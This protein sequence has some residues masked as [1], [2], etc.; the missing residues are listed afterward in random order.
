MDD[1]PFESINV[2][3][4][5]DIMLVLLTIVLTTA[6]FISAGRIPVS[7]PQAS[8]PDYEKHK[9]AIIEIAA[10]G[11][12]YFEGEAV[13]ITALE[14]RLV[15]RPSQTPVLVRADRGS[16]FQSFVDVADVLKRLKITKVGIQTERASK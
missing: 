3:P 6:S 11:E 5:V 8:K 13:S 1:K 14:T 12:I 2:V 7:L 4:L 9:E 16:K 10:G 15:E